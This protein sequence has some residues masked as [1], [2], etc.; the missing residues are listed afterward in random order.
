MYRN[1]FKLIRLGI[2]FVILM[3]GIIGLLI[4]ILQGWILILI[5]IP[6]ISPE[7]GKKMLAKVKE[8]KNKILHRT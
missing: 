4:P 8:W 2:G 5:A 7:H 1:L 6:I 3:L